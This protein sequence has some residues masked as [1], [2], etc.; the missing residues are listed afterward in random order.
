MARTDEIGRIGQ[1]RYGGTFYE[2]FLRELRGK[3]GIE[4][5]REMAENDDTIGAILFAVEMLIRQAHWTVEPGGDTAK[6]KEA[7]Q[8]VEEC[9]NDMQDTWTDTISEIL[10]FL[11]YGWSFHEIVYKRRMGKT[12]NPMT[13]SK[14]NDGLIGWRKLPIRAQ[15]TL[16]QWEYDN[17]DNLVAM[18]QL[19]P[20]DYG[21]ITIPMEKAMLFRTKSRK[22]N[23]EGR[24]ILRNAYRSWYFKRRIQEYEGIGI[25]RDLAGLPVFTA[26]QDLNIWDDDDPDM[27]KLRSGMEAMVKSI[28]VDELAGIVKPFGYEFEL[29]SSGGTKQFDTNAIIQRYD[30]GMAMTV[31][32]D[33]I[34]LGH[35]QVG[36]FAL[37]S[38]K[39]ELF[40]MA[41]GAYLDIICETFNSQGIPQLI[42][43]NGSHF[44]GITDYPTLEHGDI[45]NTDIAKLA[46][47]IKD[48]TGVGILVPDDGLEDYVREV[49]DLPERSGDTRVISNERQAQQNQSEPPEPE[50]TPGNPDESEPKEIPDEKVQ[51]AKKRLG[52]SG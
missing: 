36:S 18:T 43:I 51:A 42:D 19:P 35:Q 39:T 26:P 45:E 38:D 48:M 34:F 32:A 21:L 5:Y 9:M 15:E 27:V 11:T 23:P 33:F 25:E 31:L 30:T 41:I 47:Y 1:K 12:S 7:A 6:D 3:K 49:A 40:A 37:S 14:Y 46:A 17:Q 22:G 28:R 16:Y 29:L 52:R 24:S 10:S 50:V 20:P 8:F 4:T 13:R 44:D 2:E